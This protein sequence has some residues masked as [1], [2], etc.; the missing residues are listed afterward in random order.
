MI[1]ITKKAGEVIDLL[2]DA[3]MPLHGLS[4]TYC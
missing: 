2:K 1:K 4:E 3:V